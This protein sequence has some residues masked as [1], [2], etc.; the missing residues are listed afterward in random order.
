VFEEGIYQVEALTWGFKETTNGFDQF[1]MTFKVLGAVDR[2]N[3][4]DPPRTCEPGVRS[5]SITLKEEAN[6]AWLSDVVLSL[7]YK[8]E[9]LLGLDPDLD[10]AHDFTGVEFFAQCRHGEYKDQI[11]ESWSVYQPR[12][13]PLAKERVHDLNERLGHVLREAK[14]RK[15]PKASPKV[16]VPAGDIPF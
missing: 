2:N 13:K 12:W 8:G 1:E 15:A 14:A 7:G 3:P 4:E 10:G 6:V 5:W 11:R 16:D 9:D